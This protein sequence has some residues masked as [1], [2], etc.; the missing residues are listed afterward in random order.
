MRNYW[1]IRSKLI[2]GIGMQKNNSISFAEA[3]TTSVPQQQNGYRKD[4]AIEACEL[5]YW[6]NMN[7]DIRNNVKQYSNAWNTNKTTM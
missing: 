2:E 3:N 7:T 6:I 1:P 5:V 4:D